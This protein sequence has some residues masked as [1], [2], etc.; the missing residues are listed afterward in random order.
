M[1]GHSAV[2]V[3][4]PLTVEAC[5]ASFEVVVQV[6]HEGLDAAESVAGIETTVVMRQEEAAR[7]VPAN[8][9]AWVQGLRPPQPP[10]QIRRH[11]RGG[12]PIGRHLHVGEVRPRPLEEQPAEVL[13][14]DRDSVRHADPPAVAAVAEAE[15]L[16]LCNDVIALLRRKQASQEEGR[17]V[18]AAPEVRPRD[19]GTAE[20]VI[21]KGLLAIAQR[22]HSIEVAPSAP[23]TYARLRLARRV[24]GLERRETVR[25]VLVDRTLA[26]PLHRAHSATRRLA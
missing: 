7:A 6:D 8:P 18:A 5:G 11:S 10:Q 26:L 24:P 25:R 13:A 15:G 12:P 9:E 23:A 17:V 16:R 2:I 22:A 4:L 3:G 21:P 14:H 20:A 1:F 19:R